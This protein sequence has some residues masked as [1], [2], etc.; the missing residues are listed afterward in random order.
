MR[1]HR[2]H[3]RAG[4]IAFASL[5]ALA[6]A[7]VAGHST[8]LHHGSALAARENHTD[9][10]KREA[11][12]TICVLGICIGSSD[13]SHSTTS[14]VTKPSKSW[15][16][17]GS[18]KDGYTVDYNGNSCPSHYPKNFLWCTTRSFS[19]GMVR[20]LRRAAELTP[21]LAY[22]Q[23]APMSDGPPP[24]DSPS[25]PGPNSTSSLTWMFS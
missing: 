4:A 10:E 11:D 15:R 20:P 7:N 18:G 25:R 21:V 1:V 23:S 13:S 9:L 5:L 3:L 19:V 12:P 22:T 16:C 8:D 6:S 17:S 24:P 2:P 14:S